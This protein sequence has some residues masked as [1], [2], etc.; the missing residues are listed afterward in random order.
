M[1]NDEIF[2]L[3]VAGN[4]GAW[5]YVNKGNFQDLKT[6]AIERGNVDLERKLRNWS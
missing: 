3:L 5:A 1:T 4:A 2:D 6:I